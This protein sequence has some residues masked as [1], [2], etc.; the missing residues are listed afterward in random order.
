MANASLILETALL[1][2]AAFVVGCV[3]GALARRLTLRRPKVTTLSAAPAAD[4]AGTAPLVAAPVVA[5][6]FQRAPAPTAGERLASA[7]GRPAVQPPREA[8]RPVAPEAE[9]T[10]PPGT[11]EPAPLEAGKP[12]LPEQSVSE[13]VSPLPAEPP[14]TVPAVAATNEDRRPAR[15]AGQLCAPA[16]SAIQDA[17]PPLPA[18][19]P[20]E[21]DAESAARRAV[22]GDWTPPRR[23]APAPFPEPA[24][25]GD[26]A[27]AAMAGARSAVAAAQAAAASALAVLPREEPAPDGPQESAPEVSEEPL[28]EVPEEQESEAP[29]PTRTRRGFGA[30]ELL[31]RPRAGGKDD[32]TAIRGIS[33]AIEAS[34]NA[35]GVFHLDQLAGWDRKAV[36]WVDGHLGLKGRITREKWQEQARSLSGPARS[37]RLR[38]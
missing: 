27:E 9:E 28:P 19:A 5:P 29:A 33:P 1:L 34:L 16:E 21:N 18:P 30:P 12:V 3:V 14:E 4:G 13:P 38:R 24:V 37:V 23:L 2:L 7:A 26:E 6:L 22:E 36:V 15:I 20:A 35:L 17:Q 25:P 10:V 11:R 31:D 8:E 32:L